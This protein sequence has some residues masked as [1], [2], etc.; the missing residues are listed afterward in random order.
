[1]GY[2]Q[3]SRKAVPYCGT[4]LLTAGFIAGI[5]RVLEVAWSARVWFGQNKEAFGF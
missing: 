5:G 2:A 3:K 1:M 4:A